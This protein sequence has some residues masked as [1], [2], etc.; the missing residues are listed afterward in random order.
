MEL[1][2]KEALS[3]MSSGAEFTAESDSREGRRSS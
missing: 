2:V 1:C 3:K